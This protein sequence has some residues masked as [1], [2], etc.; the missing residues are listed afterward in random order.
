M[1]NK[2]DGTAPFMLIAAAEDSLAC[3]FQKMIGRILQTNHNW[4]IWLSASKVTKISNN[5]WE[6]IAKLC[7]NR[8]DF[9]IN[10]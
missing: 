4:E 2:K 9:K 5:I 6:K 7:Q 10:N 1:A 3:L 8:S